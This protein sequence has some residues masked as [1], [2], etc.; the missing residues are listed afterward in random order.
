MERVILGLGS[1]KGDRKAYLRNAIAS[2]SLILKDLTSSSIYQTAPQ[3]YETQDDFLNMVVIAG[4]EGTPFALLEQ[5]HEIE[6]E[7]GRNRT[8]EVPKGPR[9]LDI[10]ILFYGEL[11]LCTPTLTL[12]HPAIK[13]R[14]FV[15]AP[16]LEL[17]PDF[18]EPCG[19]LFY[20]DILVQLKE[21]RVEKIGSI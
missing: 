5:I 18:R 20:K 9:T 11:T 10:D 7:N 8:A 21:Q 13:K 19:T 6:R 4:Y 14:A 3:D 1:N 2:L 15:L 17:L 12:P 16:L